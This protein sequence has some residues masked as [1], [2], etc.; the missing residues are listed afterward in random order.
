MPGIAF[1]E[2]EP[3][4]HDY[5]REKLKAVERRFVN[6]LKVTFSS[7]RLT[8]ANVGEYTDIDILSVFIFS[9]I[10][11]AIL[12]KLPNL[13]H[14]NTMSTGYDHIDLA[15]CAKRGITVSSV[16]SYGENTVAEQAFALLLTIS[17]KILPGVERTR[18]GRYDTGPELRGFDLKDKTIGVIGTGRIGKYAIRMAKG[19][20][21]N[22]I[23]YDPYPDYTAAKDLGYTYEKDI[24]SVLAKADVISV[25]ALLTPQTKHMISMKNIDKVKKGCVFINTARGGLVETQA[26]LYALDHGIFGA[27]GL[28]VLEEETGIKEERQLLSKNY[29]GVDLRTLLQEHTLIEYD[30]VLVTP[31]NAFNTGEA[32][33]RILDTTVDNIGGYLDRKPLN[34]VKLP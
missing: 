22:V 32:L 16:P 12:A 13:K 5:L 20:S 17:R 10:T 2:L 27:V 29:G 28:D 3:W 31:H 6:P 25:H 7:E 1:F 9:R 30:N 23:A 4:E 8:D 15:A 33:R 11:P 24:D 14:I 19:F 34:L 21:M 26:V 18:R